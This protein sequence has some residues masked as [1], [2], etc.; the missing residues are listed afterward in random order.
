V[1]LRFWFCLGRLIEAWKNTPTKWYPIPVAVGALL[2]VAMQYRRK[3]TRT[4][5]EVNV[6]AEGHEIIRL[7]GPWQVRFI[8]ARVVVSI[9]KH[10]VRSTSLVPCLCETSLECGDTLIRLNYPSGYDPLASVSTH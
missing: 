4:A 5:K 3:L 7:K 1:E 6:D 8:L 10:I 2:L 9:P